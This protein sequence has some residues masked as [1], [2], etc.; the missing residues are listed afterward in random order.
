MFKYISILFTAGFVLTSCNNHEKKQVEFAK[1]KTTIV[2]LYDISTSNDE[3]ALLNESHLAKIYNKVANNGGGKFYAYLIKTDS[4]K[5]EVFEFEI[6]AID[7]LELKGNMYQIK[8]LKNKNMQKRE[9]LESHLAEFTT[10]AKQ[11]LLLPKTESFTDL[12]N[13]LHLAQTTINQPNVSST[14]INILII[15]DGINDL[16]PVDG[17]DKMESVDFGTA[18]VIL[19]RPVNRNYIIGNPTVT[20]SINDCIVNLKF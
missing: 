9:Q 3:F 14:N 18:N 12:E 4:K 7:T 5:Q 16:P 11:K 19:V 15:S 10:Q 6:P 2:L 13:A 8:K 1:P 17:P 20:N